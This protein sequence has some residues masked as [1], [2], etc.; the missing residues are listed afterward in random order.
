MTDIQEY[1]QTE[2]D[3]VYRLERRSTIH[4][5]ETCHAINHRDGDEIRTQDTA[6]IPKGYYSVCPTCERRFDKLQGVSPFE[7]EVCSRDAVGLIKMNGHTRYLCRSHYR[8]GI[9]EYSHVLDEKRLLPS[10]E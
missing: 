8:D 9:E 6:S 7:C 2:L 4:L 1:I 5:Y 10:H 3:T